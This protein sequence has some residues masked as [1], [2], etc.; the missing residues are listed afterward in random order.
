VNPLQRYFEQNSGRQIHKWVHYFD[1]YHRH[2]AKFRGRPVTVVEF[3]V[4]FGGSGQMWREYFGPDAKIYGVDIDPRCKAWDEPGFRVFIGDQSDRDFLRRIAEEI[5][6]ID[7]LIEDG[8]HRPDQQIATFE[9]MYPKVRRGGVFLIE[10]LCT[11]YWPDYDGGLARPGT[12]MEYAKRLTDKLNAWHTQEPGFAPDRFTRTTASM[13]FYDGIVVFEKDKVVA[14]H[15]EMRGSDDWAGAGAEQFG[16][17]YASRARSVARRTRR[18]VG[19]A[20]RAVRR[21]L[22]RG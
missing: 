14:P 5:G 16:Y 8:G 15:H 12:F 21:R 11:S 10:D 4:Q 17:S 13:H 19:P 6:P 1:I 18:R 3:G 9:V 7:V 22:S 2:L 20:A